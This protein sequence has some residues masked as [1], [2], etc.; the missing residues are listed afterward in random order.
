VAKAK[1]KEGKWKPVILKICT[2]KGGKRRFAPLGGGTVAV[3]KS[4]A[5][6]VQGKQNKSITN[7]FNVSVWINSG[8]CKSNRATAVM[9]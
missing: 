8:V 2:I 9:M 7:V 6:H 3:V 4:H 5:L 1:K